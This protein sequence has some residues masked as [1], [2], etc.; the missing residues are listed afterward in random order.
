MLSWRPPAI[1]LDVDLLEDLAP[2]LHD[3]SVDPADGVRP[4][5][6]SSAANIDDRRSDD[7]F[8]GLHPLRLMVAERSFS[9]AFATV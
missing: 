3:C 8:V 4:Q 5:S 7:S 6:T 2:V 1:T 9:D